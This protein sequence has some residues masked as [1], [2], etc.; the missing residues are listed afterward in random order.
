MAKSDQIFIKNCMKMMKEEIVKSK[1][2]QSGNKISPPK[3]LFQCQETMD[4]NEGK[5][6]E[7]T[8]SA[9]VLGC[10]T[11][12]SFKLFVTPQIFY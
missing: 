3:V 1:M 2:H 8:R 9:W 7:I 10:A 11:M 12:E 5:P 4:H 6:M